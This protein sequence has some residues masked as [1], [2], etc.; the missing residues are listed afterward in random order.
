MV[1]RR[2]LLLVEESDGVGGHDGEERFTFCGSHFGNRD[3]AAGIPD[4]FLVVG[5]VSGDGVLV[6]FTGFDD[7]TLPG[8]GG[9]ES[10]EARSC[11]DGGV[12]LGFGMAFGATDGVE[13]LFTKLNKIDRSSQK[14]GRNKGKERKDFVTH[15]V[16]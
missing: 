9:E 3:F 7:I 12:V 4:G 8:S 14:G 10:V 16:D 2:G 1:D 6:I 15:G 11:F 13:G 5:E